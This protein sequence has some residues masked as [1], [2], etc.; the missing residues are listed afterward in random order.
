M[1]SKL[2][3]PTKQSQ[4]PISARKHKRKSIRLTKPHNSTSYETTTTVTNVPSPTAPQVQPNDFQNENEAHD[5]PPTT[6]QHTDN[7]DE[8]HWNAVV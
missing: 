7:E 2:F 1:Q 6:P 4:L 5:L 3:L 8:A